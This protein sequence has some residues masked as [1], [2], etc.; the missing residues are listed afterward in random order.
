MPSTR[1]L[2]TARRFQRQSQARYG[3]LSHGPHLI[4]SLDC[5]QPPSVLL[6]VSPHEA[7]AQ[8]NRG[9]RVLAG[10]TEETIG[11]ENQWWCGGSATEDDGH[12]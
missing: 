7:T 4:K 9:K 10:L 5:Q 8:V 12:E 3:S 1:T 2:D 6:K 11:A